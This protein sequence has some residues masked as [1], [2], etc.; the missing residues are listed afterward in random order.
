MKFIM[1]FSTIL[2]SRSILINECD[3]VQKILAQQIYFCYKYYRKHILFH[4]S[5][6]LR[7]NL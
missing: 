1:D 7:T 5:I 4:F 6:K 3:F 2:F